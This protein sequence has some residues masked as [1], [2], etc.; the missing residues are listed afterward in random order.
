M[1]ETII[2][3]SVLVSI[4]IIANVLTARGLFV[5]ERDFDTISKLIFYL[6]LPSAIISNLNGLSFPP[7]LII[8]SIVGFLCNW[9]Y[10]FFSNWVGK[11]PTEKGFL[12]LN[13]NGYNIGNFSLPFISFFFSEVAI[14]A[15]SL[16]DAGSAFMVLGGNYGMAKGVRDG[17]AKIDVVY[18]LRTM[19]SS[20]SVIAYI[21]MIILSLLSL[22]LPSFVIDVTKIIGNGNTFLSMFMIGVALDLKVNSNHFQLLFKTLSMRYII[23]AGI[24]VLLYFFLPFSLEIRQT[25]AI[26]AFAPVSGVA[27]MYTR[28]YGENFELSAVINSLSIIISIIIMSILLVVWQG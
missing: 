2:K 16:F 25:L 21:V 7:T 8:I 24:S 28:M 5:R 27:T 9:I 19:M 18:I 14:L 1:V 13:M 10:I 26:L 3:A 15:V 4:I 22:Q 23:A 17:E 6:T 20:P 12:M 11:T